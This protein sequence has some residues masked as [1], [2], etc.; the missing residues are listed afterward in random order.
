MT[1]AVVHS[2]GNP[3]GLDL[4]STLTASI[5]A[6]VDWIQPAGEVLVADRLA[7]TSK[8]S[9]LDPSVIQPATFEARPAQS[10]GLNLE[11]DRGEIVC[12]GT[13]I[14]TD[15][16]RTAALPANETDVPILIGWN[17]MGVDSIAVGPPAEFTE[18]PFTADWQTCEIY[19][20]DTDGSTFT[21]VHDT[22]P[23]GQSNARPRVSE[24]SDIVFERVSTF[25]SGASPSDDTWY[26]VGDDRR[27]MRPTTDG[28]REVIQ[29][30][31]EGG[32]IEDWEST[33]G[34][35]PNAWNFASN[36]AVASGADLE[37]AQYGYTN[38]GASGRS[39]SDSG[40]SAY[41]SPGSWFELLIRFNSIASGGSVQTVEFGRMNPD[42]NGVSDERYQFFI[43]LNDNGTFSSIRV[44][45]HSGGTDS[46]ITPYDATPGEPISIG[47]TYR[48][49]IYWA[50]GSGTWHLEWYEFNLGGSDRL[51]NSWT[52]SAD[53]I[54]DSG[55]V[56]LRCLSYGTDLNF[57]R[58]RRPPR[59]PPN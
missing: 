55:G 26:V 38:N 8:Y 17:T 7:Q 9:A 43:N 56:A 30:R 3:Y 46:S 4:M 29:W 13:I 25:P 52:G 58:L 36:H 49:A 59:N 44:E 47:T 33:G 51:I 6:H 16:Q 40:L 22:R 20:V 18:S 28:F 15:E 39:Y 14:A 24:Q 32:M 19:R 12:G 57:D 54:H 48:A 5:N 42:S 34:T 41:P 37:G 50:E 11:F 31:K 2:P 53:I 10:S 45:Q 27:V 1:D 35:I 23:I 21:S